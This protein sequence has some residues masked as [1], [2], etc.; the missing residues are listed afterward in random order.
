MRQM[1]AYPRSDRLSSSP[2]VYPSAVLA[3]I[4]RSI[5]FSV[6]SIV[7]RFYLNSFDMS[8]DKAYFSVYNQG[9]IRSQPGVTGVAPGEQTQGMKN[10]YQR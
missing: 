8:I 3:A 1:V 10:D 4:I 5:R 6:F 7:I 2:M 9:V